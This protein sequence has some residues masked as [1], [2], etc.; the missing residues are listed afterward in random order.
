MAT[1][2]KK[3]KKTEQNQDTGFELAGADSVFGDFNT[4]EGE[5]PQSVSEH[6]QGTVQGIAKGSEAAA[7][8]I[9]IEDIQP[10]KNQP[11][12]YFEE[13]KL[14][15]LAA[16]FKRDGFKGTLLVRPDEETE[17]YTIV[18]GERRWRAAKIAGLTEI[19][20]MVSSMNDAQAMEFAMGENLLREDLSK[21]EE[22]EGLLSILEMHTRLTAK[23][24]ESLVIKQAHPRYMENGSYVGT[25]EKAGE[26]LP[27]I[28][29]I[30][31][32]CGISISTF[33]SKHLQL[34]KLHEDVRKAHLEKDLHYSKA[35]EV[36]KIPD[37]A[38]RQALLQR[39]QGGELSS[40]SEIKK[41]V[42]EAVEHCRKE[43][44]KPAQELRT[45]F[46]RVTKQV[47]SAK[48]WKHIEQD[49]RK[50]KKI[51]RLLTQLNELVLSSDSES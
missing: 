18:Y 6:R 2:K 9:A 14:Q 8:N 13:S 27:E 23:E 48:N 47:G 22:A 45:Q 28:G 19:P 37:S 35:L 4:D 16:S 41:S 49:S 7:I 43:E 5:T 11:R 20:C 36:Q 21:L 15:D 50:R 3:T 30:L 12:K 29:E 31:E 10:W 32:H 39:I 42:K 24:I 51:E 44:A 38:L 25:N 40:L 1:A 33:R 17:R 46:R 34:R 26:Y